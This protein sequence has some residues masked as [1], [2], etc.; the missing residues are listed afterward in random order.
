MS[1]GASYLNKEF[2][3]QRIWSLVFFC[4]SIARIRVSAQDPGLQKQRTAGY[5][6]SRRENRKIQ[7]PHLE[8]WLPQRPVHD[9][10]AA[11]LK[12]E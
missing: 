7:S 12:E 3:D 2:K 4:I 10:V 11:G 1:P 8:S 6:H 5:H 9:R